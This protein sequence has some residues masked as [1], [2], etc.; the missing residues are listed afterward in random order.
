MKQENAVIILDNICRAHTWIFSHTRSVGL[1]VK[2]IWKFGKFSWLLFA[3]CINKL[4][5]LVNMHPWSYSSDEEATQRRSYLQYGRG[6][7]W[8]HK[9]SFDSSVRIWVPQGPFLSFSLLWY[10]YMFHC[11]CV[12]YTFTWHVLHFKVSKIVITLLP[13]WWQWHSLFL[14]MAVMEQQNVDWGSSQPHYCKSVRAL[15]WAST[16]PPRAW[17]LPTCFWGTGSSGFQF[18]FQAIK[19]I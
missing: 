3:D 9:H 10:A 17:S 5:G 12:A 14:F 11:Q 15:V 6:W 13:W 16:L 8:R 7:F 1:F 4:D 2:E 18:V 19:K